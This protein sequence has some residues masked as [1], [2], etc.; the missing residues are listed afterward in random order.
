MSQLVGFDAPPPEW[1]PGVVVAGALT[2]GVVVAGVVVT[3]ELA[4]DEEDEP[5]P[6]DVPVTTVL[7]AGEDDAEGLLVA[8]V[9][10]VVAAVVWV[11]GVTF[12][13]AAALN[14]SRVWLVGAVRWAAARWDWPGVDAGVVGVPLEAGGAAMS[15]LA[16]WPCS[17]NGTATIAATITTAS[18]QSRRSKRSRFRD[19]ILWPPC[20]RP[21]STRPN[22]DRWLR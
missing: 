4:A 11:V 3:G 17:R 16:L 5:A 8:L 6:L 18:G 14:G 10:A 22:V 15:A 12:A 13:A 20:F 2:A 19:F 21:P 9:A 1:V 7:L